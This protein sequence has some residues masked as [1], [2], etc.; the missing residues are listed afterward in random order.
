MGSLFFGIIQ[1]PQLCKAIGKQKIETSEQSI[2][3]MV[4]IQHLNDATLCIKFLQTLGYEHVPE[5]KEL[6]PDRRYFRKGNM[7]GTE[8]CSTHPLHIAE[9]GASSGTAICCSGTIY[10]ITRRKSNA[11]TDYIPK[12]VA[13]ARVGK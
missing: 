9:V 1:T 12:I 4:G 2:D 5:N 3:I 8:Q 6:I 7:P 11:K 10:G 13:K